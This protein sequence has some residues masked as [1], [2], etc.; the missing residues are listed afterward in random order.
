MHA[1]SAL[2]LYIRRQRALPISGGTG[3]YACA[4]GFIEAT[5]QVGTQTFLD[6]NYCLAC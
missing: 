2:S 3:V 1:A 6:V 5:R 4:S